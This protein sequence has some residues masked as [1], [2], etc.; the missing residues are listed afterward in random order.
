MGGAETGGAGGL[1]GGR[2]G[3]SARGGRGGTTMGGL[4]AVPP[5][6]AGAVAGVWGVGMAT[7]NLPP[8][9]LGGRGPRGSIPGDGGGIAVE[10]LTPDILTEGSMS[11]LLSSGMPDAVRAAGVCAARAA[12][13]ADGKCG[14]IPDEG[15]GDSR[16][17]EHTTGAPALAGRPNAIISTGVCVMANAGVCVTVSVGPPSSVAVGVI[18]AMAAAVAAAALSAAAL[19]SAENAEALVGI[20][21]SCRSAAS[22]ASAARTSSML[23]LWLLGLVC[24]RETLSRSSSLVFS[25]S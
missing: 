16:N 1:R 8:G 6:I 7:G 23:V 19:P 25:A 22:W 17:G 10:L 15:A 11:V 4:V 24:G 12:W 21:I 14:G 20:G 13:S 2:G 5:C 9:S 3:R 18:N